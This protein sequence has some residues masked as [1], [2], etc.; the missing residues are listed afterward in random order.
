M[1]GYADDYENSRMNIAV[2]HYLSDGTI[3]TSF[4]DK[5]KAITSLGG[6]TTLVYSVAIQE[7]GKIV[8]AGSNDDYDGFSFILIR[9]NSDGSLDNDFGS[10]RRYR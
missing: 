1:I 4:G 6:F 7:D 10:S 9:Y 5:G 3:D 8:V 2:V